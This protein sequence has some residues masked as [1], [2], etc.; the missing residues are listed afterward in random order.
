MANLLTPAKIIEELNEVLQAD[1]DAVGTYQ[2]AIDAIDELNIKNQ[3]Y[4]F[5]RD[6]ERHI[7]DLEALVQRSGGKPVRKADLKGMLQR[8][9][10]KVAGLVGTEASLRAMLK[11]EKTTNGVYAH[12][13][14][15]GFPPDI[16]EVLRRNYNDE[17]RHY[18]WIDAALRTRLWEQTQPTPTP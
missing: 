12:H 13:L 10:T 1:V 11:N 5:K 16:L 14:Q 6:H 15:M 8:G 9:F 18:A 4:D 3:L 2:D 7:A 17:Q